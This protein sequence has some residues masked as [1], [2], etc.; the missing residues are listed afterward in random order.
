MDDI[1]AF[2]VA[3]LVEDGASGWQYHDWLCSAIE[4][5]YDDGSLRLNHE[6]CDCGYPARVLREVEAKRNTIERYVYCR[7]VADLAGSWLDEGQ[8]DGLWQAVIYMLQIYVEHPD[9]RE[10]WGVDG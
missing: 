1:L 7:K 4:P 5:N 2:L 8:A 6:E 9:Y 3:R 10:E